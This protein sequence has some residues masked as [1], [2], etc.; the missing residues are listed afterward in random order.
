MTKILSILVLSFSLS[1][2]A[3]IA[4]VSKIWPK[5]HDPAM[6]SSFVNLSIALDNADCDNKQT[7]K[8]VQ[9]EAD[10]LNRYA[11][12]RDDPQK[13]STKAIL[14]NIDKAM[15]AEGTT[16]QRWVNLSKTRMKIIQQAWSGR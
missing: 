1:G 16:C 12:V 5:D 9:K 4:Y 11:E 2:C 14:D 15:A 7:L 8:A 10:W 6:I 13:V 3:A